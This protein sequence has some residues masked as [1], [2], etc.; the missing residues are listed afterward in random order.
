LAGYIGEITKRV[1]SKS[2]MDIGSFL[3]QKL[4]LSKSDKDEIA[5][6][7]NDYIENVLLILEDEELTQFLQEAL[8]FIPI[9]I[10]SKEFDCSK[11]KFLKDLQDNLQPHYH[12]LIVYK[13]SYDENL[14]KL[15]KLLYKRLKLI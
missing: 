1:T 3:D 2:I 5:W 9:E 14:R 10:L 15:A 11:Y 4:E 12:K 6:W 7:A 8:Q 13:R